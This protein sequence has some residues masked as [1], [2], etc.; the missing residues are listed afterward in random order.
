[1]L[2]SC[3]Q[4]RRDS[5]RPDCNFQRGAYN[6]RE[7]HSENMRSIELKKSVNVGKNI[8]MDRPISV[9]HFSHGNILVGL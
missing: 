1:M 3:L 2:H 5:C 4:S 8:G 7:C 9:Y 6:I